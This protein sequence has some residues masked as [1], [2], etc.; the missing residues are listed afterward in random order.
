MKEV[1]PYN[2]YIDRI[3]NY[4]FATEWND[5]KKKKNNNIILYLLVYLQWN[6]CH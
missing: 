3:L 2:A 5:L 4:D 1:K 6:F